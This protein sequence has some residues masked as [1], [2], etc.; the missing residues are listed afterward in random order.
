[1]L[2]QAAGHALRQDADELPA[3]ENDGRAD[4]SQVAAL[5]FTAR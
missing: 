3:L 4:R 1:V 5:D 2:D